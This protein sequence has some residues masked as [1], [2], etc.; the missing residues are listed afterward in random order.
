[1]EKVVSFPLLKKKHS[2]IGVLWSKKE[3]TELS[4]KLLKFYI[5]NCLIIINEYYY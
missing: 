3:Y 4:H 2:Y 5:I 1:M